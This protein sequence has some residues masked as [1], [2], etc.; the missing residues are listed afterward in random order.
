MIKLDPL[1]TIRLVKGF[2]L[3]DELRAWDGVPEEPID[4]K[5]GDEEY[6]ERPYT[7]SYDFPEMHESEEAERKREIFDTRLKYALQGVSR[8]IHV[9]K[10]KRPRVPRVICISQLPDGMRREI[11][12]YMYS[13]RGY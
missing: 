9:G 7:D 6:S 2:S 3:N 4:L 13:S 10:S 8:A 1:Y 12:H 11:S 5:A